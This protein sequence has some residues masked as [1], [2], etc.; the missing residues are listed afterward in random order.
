MKFTK[1][2]LFSFAFNFVIIGFAS[3]Y[4]FVIP[5]MYFYHSKA[6]AELYYKCTTCLVAEKNAVIDFEKEKYQIIWWGLLNETDYSTFKSILSTEYDITL[7][8]GG[9]CTSI[10]EMQCYSIKMQ[11]LLN[12]KYGSGFMAKAYKKAEKLDDSFHKNY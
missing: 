7:F 9:K 4:Y 6:Y 3:A 10:P 12:K 2:V 5:E 11:K 1:L 8:V